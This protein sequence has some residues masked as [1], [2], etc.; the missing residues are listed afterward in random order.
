M[1]EEKDDRLLEFTEEGRRELVKEC[2]P[3][4]SEEEGIQRLSTFIK[5]MILK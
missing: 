5:Y 4:L 3:E 2:W 1:A